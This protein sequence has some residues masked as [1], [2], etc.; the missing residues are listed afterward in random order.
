MDLSEIEQYL[1]DNKSWAI[2]LSVAFV[3]VLVLIFF[4]TFV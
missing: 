4:A 1:E 3:L 2:G